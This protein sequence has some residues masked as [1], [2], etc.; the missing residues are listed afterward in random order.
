MSLIADLLR[1]TD[2]CKLRMTC[3]SVEY[4]THF[5]FARR[6]YGKKEV[7]LSR[8]NLEEFAALVN[9]SNLGSSIRK[10]KLFRLDLIGRPRPPSTL[11]RRSACEAGVVVQPVDLV[12]LMGQMPNLKYVVLSGVTCDSLALCLPRESYGN[13]AGLSVRM[14][15]LNEARLTSEDLCMF[16]EAFGTKLERLELREVSSTDGR[17]HQVLQTIR[18]KMQLQ[19]LSLTGLRSPPTPLSRCAD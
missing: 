9:G 5:D 2:L 18:S 17:W 1:M 12:K 16:L 8:H 6:A 14:L 19:H 7:T 11:E 3:R 15:R 4:N 10:L 13:I